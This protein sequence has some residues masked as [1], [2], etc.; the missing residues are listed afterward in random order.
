MRI[1]RL[2]ILLL[3]LS[4]LLLVPTNSGEATAAPV[5]QQM[6][7]VAAAF[8]PAAPPVQD[9]DDA[10][11]LAALSAAAEAP[12]PTPFSDDT[13]NDG[14]P[15]EPGLNCPLRRRIIALTIGGAPPP[16]ASDLTTPWPTGPP[17]V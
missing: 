16:S 10:L 14:L 17:T 7:T 8:D 6:M 13:G 1:H 11:L 4:V 12:A 9:D 2:L 3:S 5:I 15:A